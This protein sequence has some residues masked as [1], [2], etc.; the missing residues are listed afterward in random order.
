[1]SISKTVFD[2]CPIIKRYCCQFL[3]GN[4]RRKKEAINVEVGR[5]LGSGLKRN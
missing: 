2:R 4:Y 5:G 1:M 3:M